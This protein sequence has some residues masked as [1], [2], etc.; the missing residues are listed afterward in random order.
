MNLKKKI[1]DFFNITS[2]DLQS[3]LPESVE[4]ELYFIYAIF[5]EK[6]DILGKNALTI[7]GFLGVIVTLVFG[8]NIKNHQFNSVVGAWFTLLFLLIALITKIY[9]CKKISSYP[10]SQDYQENIYC[11][12]FLASVKNSQ[13]LIFLIFKAKGISKD[14]HEGNTLSTDHL[15]I[16]ILY[17]SR[18]IYWKTYVCNL[19]WRVLI[20][21][22]LIP[23]V[24]YMILHQ[25]YK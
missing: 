15:A 3:S 13:E 20:A 24:A 1:I 6:Y 12:Y 4:K 17:L 16:Q 25:L 23:L 18:M 2:E 10:P 19:F 21:M 7:L 8:W 9:K 14:Y 22:I 5:Q 11:P